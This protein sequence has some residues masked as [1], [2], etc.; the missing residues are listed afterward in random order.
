MRMTAADSHE[1]EGSDIEPELDDPFPSEEEA[2][3]RDAD[4]ELK[5]HLQY[6]SKTAKLILEHSNQ[7]IVR[8]KDSEPVQDNWI[9][10]TDHGI[11]RELLQQQIAEAKALT[12]AQNKEKNKAEEVYETDTDIGVED[13][14]E[15]FDRDEIKNSPGMKLM[16]ELT[17]PKE[18]ELEEDEILMLDPLLTD[19]QKHEI[20]SSIQLLANLPT[21]KQVRDWKKGVSPAQMGLILKGAIRAGISKPDLN[22]LKDF[23]NHRRKISN[24]QLHRFR[25]IICT[26]LRK[27]LMEELEMKPADKSQIKREGMDKLIDNTLEKDFEAFD[28]DCGMMT[29]ADSG[30]D[31]DLRDDYEL[32]ESDLVDSDLE[33]RNE[34]DEEGSTETS[35]RTAN[36]LIDYAFKIKKVLD[37]QMREQLMEFG[38]L[39]SV[40]P[41]HDEYFNIDPPKLGVDIDPCVEIV[42][43]SHIQSLTKYDSLQHTQRKVIIKVKI[44]YLNFPP[45]VLERFIQ[46]VGSRYDPETGIFKY[47]SK[48]QHNKHQNT[49]H[50]LRQIKKLFDA[51]FEALPSYLPLN[52]IENPEDSVR[53]C[54][55]NLTIREMYEEPYISAKPWQKESKVL[56]PRDP[57]FVFRVFPFGWN[58]KNPSAAPEK[59]IN[60]Q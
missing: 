6:D 46:I 50:G 7:F 31:Y 35:F 15:E 3:N 20:Y 9:T 23:L 26:D 4:G 21:E 36:Y 38:L 60:E 43:V 8:S 12:E 25:D 59:T 16:E 58:T 5:E 13:F 10:K 37:Y 29:G 39:D 24:E 1:P 48:A 56:K 30:I 53:D 44:P 40:N 54:P 45:E 27:N 42:H 22:F 41:D 32:E 57:Y 51:S 19:Q 33:E 47:V 11:T 55:V 17:Q 14:I 52:E 2:G 49:I 34:D 18:E 28:T